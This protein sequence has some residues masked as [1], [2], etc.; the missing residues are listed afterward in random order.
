MFP[1]MS[2]GVYQELCLENTLLIEFPS[3]L[4]LFLTPAEWE[5]LQVLFFRFPA[6]GSCCL[7]DFL[8]PPSERTDK[9]W[10]GAER[11]V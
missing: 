9:S 7:L 1:V 2:T 11:Q 10:V 6:P 3:C 5:I 4:H 8:N